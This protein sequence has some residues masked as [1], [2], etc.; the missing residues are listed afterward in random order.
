MKF[1]QTMSKDTAK[2][3]LAPKFKCPLT[4]TI[5]SNNPNGL[6]NASIGYHTEFHRNECSNLGA[7]KW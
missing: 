5:V 6:T 4:D 2:F 3:Y 7:F 1:R